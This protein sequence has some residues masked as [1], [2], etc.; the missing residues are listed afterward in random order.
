MK[1]ALPSKLVQA[2][3]HPN[4]TGRYQIKISNRTQIILSFVSLA[5]VCPN[6]SAVP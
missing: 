3:M 1:A 2:A 5:L 4:C 6:S